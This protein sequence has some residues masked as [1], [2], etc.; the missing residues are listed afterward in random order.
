VFDELRLKRNAARRFRIGVEFVAVNAGAPEYCTDVR[1]LH[2]Q[3]W[4]GGLGHGAASRRVAGARLAQGS[5]IA[6]LRCT[7]ADHVSQSAATSS[8]SFTQLL[9]FA[10]DIAAGMVHLVECGILHR[11]L[12]ARNVLLSA[13]SDRYVAKVSVC[14]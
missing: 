2:A 3:W 14:V 1:C 10:K 6:V 5:A 8:F 4:T 7:V 12:A 13:Q 9:L 11:D